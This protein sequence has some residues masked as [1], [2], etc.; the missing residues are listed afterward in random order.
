MIKVTVDGYIRY[1][2]V[3]CLQFCLFFRRS[4]SETTYVF[5]HLPRCG[6]T[7]FRMGLDK[8]KNTYDDYRIGWTNIYPLKYK[9][10][11][12][13]NKDCLCGHFE[14]SGN[15]IFERYP[16]I[17]ENNRFVLWTI[18]RNPLEVAL[19]HY[20]Y[21]KKTEQKVPSDIKEYL[22]STNN[23]LAEVL[24]V[25]AENYELI[26][27][28]YDFIGIFENMEETLSQFK[29]ILNIENLE[30]DMLNHAKRED[31]SKV[32]N[33]EDILNFENQNSLDYKI[34]N[35]CL[36]RFNSKRN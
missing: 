18:I 19:S 26:L 32:I 2:L 25:S 23:Y 16:E 10:S 27:G 13:S 30:L 29:V 7:S 33:P 22:N 11:K 1:L 28:R 31:L 5:H 20:F 4:K 14:S 21:K 36:E 8:V 17:Y 6:G 35:Y 24:N 3:L 12:F 34:Y 9:T 15:H